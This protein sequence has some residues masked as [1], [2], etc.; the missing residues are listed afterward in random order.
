MNYSLNEVHMTLRKALCGRGLAFGAADDFGAVGARLSSGAACDGIAAVLA[1]DNSALIALLHR[2]ETTMAGGSSHTALAAGIE[3]T[4]AA[5]LQGHP[6]PRDRAC[7]IS[8]ESWQQA[9]DLS[10]LTYVPETEASRL[11]GAGAGTNDND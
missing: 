2:V 6:F 9:L 10:H 7:A 1:F 8:A 11:G 4:L 3:Q 5:Q